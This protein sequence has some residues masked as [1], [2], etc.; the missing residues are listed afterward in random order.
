MEGSEKERVCLEPEELLRR[1]YETGGDRVREPWEIQV[2]S[3]TGRRTEAAREERVGEVV[4]ALA[5]WPVEEVRGG[6]AFGDWRKTLG[7]EAALREDEPG[8]GG[9]VVGGSTCET[10]RGP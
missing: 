4:L 2:A 5:G 6:M 1:G 8:G 7:L 9:M 3:G 10:M